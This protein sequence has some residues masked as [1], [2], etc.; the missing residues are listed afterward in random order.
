MR[1]RSQK[2]IGNKVHSHAANI[3]AFF[4]HLFPVGNRLFLLG[5]R[6]LPWE[7]AGSLSNAYMLSIYFPAPLDVLLPVPVSYLFVPVSS[8]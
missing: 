6:T 1:G 5:Y 8:V 7:A 2:K 3:A 4:T